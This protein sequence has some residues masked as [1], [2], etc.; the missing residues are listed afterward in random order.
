MFI[1][2]FLLVIGCVNFVN[3]A[4]AQATAR[5]HE[6]G[7]RKVLGSGRWH[8]AQQFLTETALIVGFA[9]IIALGLTAV[10][11][12]VVNGITQ[13]SIAFNL[14]QNLPL[15]LVLVS[16]GLVVTVVAGFYP[17]VVLSAFG[18]LRAIRKTTEAS[19]GGRG[20]S[21]RRILVVL[22]FVIAQVLIVCMLVVSGQLN[23]FRNAPMGFEK[24]NVLLV[25][26]PNDSLSQT[27]W[28][29]CENR[30][31]SLAGVNGIS[32]STFPP[33]TDSHWRSDFNFDHSPT[34]TPFNADLQW[35]EPGFLSL[36][37][38]PLVAGRIYHQ[39]DTPREFVVNEMLV[40]KLGFSSPD[41]ILGKQVSFWKGQYAGPIVGVVK[42]FHVRS[43]AS[44]ITPVVFGSWR[45]VF[46]YLNVKIQPEQ[47]RDVL[48][49]V[50][51]IWEEAFPK[52]VYE[53]QF[54][55]QK[56]INFYQRIDQLSLLYRIFAFIAIFLSSL[57]LYGLVSFSTERRVK[58]VGVRK[59]LGASV[60]SVVKLFS[61]EFTILVAVAFTVAAP[62]AYVLMSR[63]LENYAY[64][65]SPG[66]GLFLAAFAGSL[67]VAW[68][69]V[70]Y[71]AFRAA[72]ANPVE[73]LRYE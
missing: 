40:K 63:W 19:S 55:D 6:T 65:I 45:D 35:A 10:F 52:Y 59:V 34:M 24:G 18:P 44:E 56:I 15:L 29:A 11:L 12:P 23:F 61:R 36:Y 30:I 26:V 49:S 57:G 73:S 5:A 13:E 66:V 50:R 72:L 48:A 37:E 68:L 69:A 31:A 8:I 39:S 32:F 54:L 17:A 46:R 22:Q 70:G 43:L 33:S 71:R 4:T 16:L 58:E 7:V 51:Q 41:A 3:L 20:I 42:D 9:T 67:V 62:L 2:L 1:A 53:S 38:V 60:W 21:L 64:H 14:V 28:Q 25:P 27:H 47:T